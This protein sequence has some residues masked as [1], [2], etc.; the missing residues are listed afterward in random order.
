MQLC[1]LFFV[2]LYG[3]FCFSSHLSF[4]RKVFSTALKQSLFEQDVEDRNAM[5][6]VD[7]HLARRLIAMPLTDVF[8]PNQGDMMFDKVQY[9]DKC[10]LPTSI[11]R[12]VFE[13]RLEVPWLFEV[14][15]AKR[16]NTRIT[17]GSNKH[18]IR[19]VTKPTGPAQLSEAQSE[20]ESSYAVLEKAYLSPLD[21]RSP[22]NYV[23]M[24]QWLMRNLNV[25]ANDVVD[26]S[27]VR[28]K[29]ASL[30]V[31]QP[32]SIEWDRFIKNV[33]YPKAL[34]EHEISKYSSLTSGATIYIKVKGV[35]YPLLVKATYA[36]GGIAVKGVRVQDADIR[37][38]IDRSIV[39]K[40]IQIEKDKLKL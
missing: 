24:P 39:D 18:D 28:I 31:F 10:S 26:V 23:Y 15:P 14:K 33:R 35:E 6:K 11:G 3:K 20:L 5:H 7:N 13:K 2:V 19:S 12:L 9:G 37:T 22:E 1:L 34:L 17:W 32:L 29:L 25:S 40:L 8:K 16:S 27:F 36:E 30:V 38:D 21:F 4:F